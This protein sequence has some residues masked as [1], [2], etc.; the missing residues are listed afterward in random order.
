MVV[1]VPLVVVEQGVFASYALVRASWPSC[2]VGCT[3]P[4]WHSSKPEVLIKTV[5]TDRVSGEVARDC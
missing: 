4:F 3:L 5:V 2:V 1:M